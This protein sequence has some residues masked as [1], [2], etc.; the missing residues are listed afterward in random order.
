MKKIST[1]A[2]FILLSFLILQNSFGQVRINVPDYISRK[3]IDYCKSVP[4]EDVFLHTDRDEYIA[5]EELWFTVYAFD[6]QTLA[7]SLNSRL[8]YVE[9]VSPD[10][11]PLIKARFAIDK[12][13]GPGQILLPDT[14]SSGLYTIRAYT[15]WMKNFLPDNCFTKDIRIYNAISSKPF[16]G[17]SRQSRIVRGSV[18]QLGKISVRV[19]N[20]DPDS[21]EIGINADKEFI[22]SGNET[23]Y[24]FIETRGNI[25]LIRPEKLAGENTRITL[26]RSL[27]MPGINHI[28]LFDKNILPV[29]ERFI[30]SAVKEEKQKIAIHSADIYKNRSRVSL[31]IDNE[32]ANST[33]AGGNLSISVSPLTDI[34]ASQ[35]LGRYLVFGS[36]F[37]ELPWEILQGRN[38]GELTSDIDS[39]LESLESNWI[40]WP[41][42]FAAKETHFRYMQESEDHYLSGK[43]I[44]KDQ[45]PAPYG[46]PV[47]LSIPGKTAVFQY[48]LT[49]DEGNFSFPLPI[50][51]ETRDLIIQPGNSAGNFKMVMETS[52]S[53]LI[54]AV[55][56]KNNSAVYTPS[57]YISEW[58]SNFQV[59]RIYG[60]SSTGGF[61]KPF[62]SP[63]QAR[64]FYG[65]PELEIRLD[66]YIKLPVMEE[67][68]FELVPRVI[69]KND[70]SAY[71]LYIVDPLRV[72][73][74]DEPPVMMVNGVIF[75]DPAVIGSMDPALV[76]KIDVIREKYV[77]G[78]Y[79]FPGIVNVITKSTDYKNMPV[80]LNAVRIP[81]VVA[82]PVASF[83]S[84]DYST[85]GFKNSRIPDF[86]NTLYWNP[87]LQPDKNGK[88]TVEFWSSD[89][90]SDYLIKIEGV[91]GDGKIV[92]LKKTISVK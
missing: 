18:P 51:E 42:V 58:S 85:E 40:R 70:R 28:T 75:D 50:D 63:P 46:E 7:P 79:R 3:F 41:A 77:V 59:A 76:E 16:R 60:I 44:K 86:R 88:Y 6:R 78:D 9:V 89:F 81:Y 29:C 35:E 17:A 82:E 73:L 56:S 36:E 61:L 25:N 38:I 45:Q 66:D 53:D 80:P 15:G 48:A 13:Y 12:G 43:L 54:P 31:E 8:V 11:R 72:R 23:F 39:L 57:S 49:D 83:T 87:S 55:G 68:F 64:R 69:L 32:V 20:H 37:G 34:T 47:L 91:T 10:N 90:A 4:R 62:S 24:L 92:S 65:K 14:L 1:P 22:N 26:S 27:L 33:L 2:L 67:V 19:N 5:G 30:F 21:L 52:F 84:P 71:E 74:Y